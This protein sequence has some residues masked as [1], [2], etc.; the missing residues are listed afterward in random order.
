[1]AIRNLNQTIKAL[2]ARIENPPY[3]DL[4]CDILEY[5]KEYSSES[6]R[7]V[8]VKR[9]PYSDAITYDSDGECKCGKCVDVLWNYCPRCGSKLDWSE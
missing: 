3:G 7:T 5:L 6:E 8:K 4:D 2:E 9:V 1:M